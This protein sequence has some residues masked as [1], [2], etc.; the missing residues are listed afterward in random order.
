MSGHS[1]WA[2]IKRKK[3]VTDVR[4]GK[5]FTRLAREIS[6]A[7]RLGGGDPGGNPRLR[8]AITEAKAQSLPR[9]NIERAI[10][11]G[12]GEL[13]GETYEEAVFEGYAPGGVAILVEALTDNRNRTVSD[14]RHTFSKHG[15]NLGENGCV[16]WMFTKKGIF[17]LPKDALSESELMDLAVEAGAE[18]VEIREDEYLLVSAVED[19]MHIEEGLEQRSVKV[20]EQRLVMVSQTF[21]EVDDHHHRQAERLIDAIDELDDVQNVWSN[22]AGELSTTADA[23]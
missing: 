12:T 9:D 18:D 3:A 2:Q 6:V 5:L 7:A 19:F 16:A 1:K 14:L 11:K 21:A 23:G 10:Q 15:G 17:S 20:D 4:R 22:L 8:A 13:A